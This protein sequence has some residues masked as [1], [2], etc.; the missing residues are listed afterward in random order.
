MLVKGNSK[1]SVK[2]K[3]ISK[4]FK[5]KVRLEPLKGSGWAPAPTPAPAKPSQ[6]YIPPSH[7]Y[8][9][10]PSNSYVPAKKW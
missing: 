4:F 10:P 7:A 2:F 6:A 9:P 8:V 5:A 1:K 3:I